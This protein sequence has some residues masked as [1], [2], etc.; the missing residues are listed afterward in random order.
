MNT[1]QQ[2]LQEKIDNDI[3]NMIANKESTHQ[4]NE[5]LKIDTKA[6]VIVDKNI[7]DQVEEE[8]SPQEESKKTT[9]SGETFANTVDDFISMAN[10]AAAHRES[11]SK[12]IDLDALCI[13]NILNRIRQDGG[14]IKFSIYNTLTPSLKDKLKQ[15]ATST[16]VGEA[17][18][19]VFTRLFF[20][21]L[22]QDS[23]LDSA[24]GQL[25]KD[26]EE[27]NRMPEQMDIFG[28]VIFKKMIHEGLVRVLM[29]NETDSSINVEDNPITEVAKLTIDCWYL[30]PLY[31]GVI[32][33]I[34]K[35]RKYSKKYK[36]NI[37]DIEYFFSKY[38][39][40][41]STTNK[42]GDLLKVLSTKNIIPNAH[43]ILASAIELSFEN[44][45][46]NN[47]KEYIPVQYVFLHSLILGIL[48]YINPD[49]AVQTE[50]GKILWDSYKRFLTFVDKALNTEEDP[51]EI[52]EYK[53][54]TTLVS[55]AYEEELTKA[56]NKS[57]ENLSIKDT[58][59]SEKQDESPQVE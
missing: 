1:I 45:D 30:K 27:A 52:D 5:T 2:Q 54:T 46:Q 19:R 36:Q 47:P 51:R 40:K 8:I 32:Q 4:S 38:N 21:Q 50:E 12:D 42:P 59:T 35:L 9:L 24:W 14:E 28:S 17:N 44:L 41:S 3:D 31:E 26:L 29:A 15:V 10:G 34:N 58:S 39:I 33:R 37:S 43:Q 13:F 20:S 7:Y 57:K 16:G 48:A 23:E 11:G 25:Q 53:Q 18:I 55:K 49:E 6:G 22:Y 56:K